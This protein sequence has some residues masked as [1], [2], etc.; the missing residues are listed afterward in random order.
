MSNWCT[1]GQRSIPIC[2]PL[3][4]SFSC[5]TIFQYWSQCTECVIKLMD[6]LRYFW[7][8]PVL[9]NW[10]TKGYGVNYPVCG[11]VYI[12]DPLPLIEISSPWSDSTG[13]SLIL[14]GLL[15]YIQHDITINKMHSVCYK[16]ARCSSVVRAFAHGAMGHRINPSL[17][18]FSF[19]PVPHDWCNKG[20]G[21]CYPVC[22]MMH[23][24]EPLLLIEKSSLCG[25][26][27]FPLSLSE[28]F[29]TICLKPYNRK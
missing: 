4:F 1:V 26:R 12:K 20:C 19:Q 28:W 5:E 3:F 21:M 29:F 23:I 10:C 24:K 25:S 11:V 17:G 27:G 6:P 7:L 15:L 14:S 13:F 22:G 8:Q 18:Y 9:H 2:D 16:G